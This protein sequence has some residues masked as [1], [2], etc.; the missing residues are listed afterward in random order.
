MLDFTQRPG[1]STAAAWSLR[2]HFT[3]AIAAIALLIA[4]GCAS[5][6]TALLVEGQPGS[7]IQDVDGQ[8]AATPP[9]PASDAGFF[10]WPNPAAVVGA[11]STDRPGFAD[12][13][14]LMPRG[15]LQL[16]LGYTFTQ[17]Q[18][19]GVRTRDHAIAQTNLRAGLRNDLE[20]RLLWN[21]LS[22]TETSTTRGVRETEHDDGAGDITVGVR[23]KLLEND[24][25]VPDLAALVNLS[26]PVGASTKSAGEVVPDLRLA[27]GWAL[28]ES[29]RL[30]GVAIAAAAVDDEGRFLQGAGSAGLSWGLTDDIGTF[31]EY[32]GIFQEGRGGPSHNL[33]GGFT[34]VLSDDVQLDAS[35]GVGL[36]QQ[37]P[38]FFVGTGLSLRW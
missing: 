16:E 26:I 19:D 9:A 1:S 31:V 36:N 25:L 2:P 4:S 17:D 13:T 8:A 21:G 33:D 3:A 7:T 5:T 6:P 34:F 20:L 24:G 11:L 27:Y 10:V 37:A 38:D 18:E 28:T 29:L 12:S 22:A 30:Y 14:T 32:F 23:A 15:H 35:A